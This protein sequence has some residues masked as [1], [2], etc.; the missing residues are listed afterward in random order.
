MTDRLDSS[1][2]QQHLLH[3]ETFIVKNR[4]LQ[5]VLFDLSYLFRYHFSLIQMSWK[6]SV[7]D[8][9]VYIKTPA[10]QKLHVWLKW[11]LA[12]TNFLR[13]S[14]KVQFLISSFRFHEVLLYAQQ[15]PVHRQI[16]PMTWQLLGQ[17]WL[18]WKILAYLLTWFVICSEQTH[19]DES[20]VRSCWE[21]WW[22]I[23]DEED[24]FCWRRSNHQLADADRSGAVA[25]TAPLW[26][27]QGGADY[28]HLRHHLRHGGRRQRMYSGR[29]LPQ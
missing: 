5:W 1:T 2:A 20:D 27:L 22:S 17:R 10:D 16:T 26:A 18:R 14:P 13:H 29:H 3:V 21:W 6:C 9:C 28:R 11:T 15:R 7:V 24:D 8:A 12:M 23:V 25:G 19:I 4:L